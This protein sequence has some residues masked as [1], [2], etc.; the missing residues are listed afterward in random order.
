MGC[1]GGG[2]NTVVQP[3]RVGPKPDTKFE[4]P[5]KDRKCRDVIALIIFV[6]FLGVM[7]YV[8][9][10]AINKGNPQLLFY[11]TDSFGNVC[12]QD[13]D[14]IDG[15]AL[16]GR[17]T[18]G[19]KKLFYFDES[20]LTTVST[21]TTPTTTSGSVCVKTCPDAVADV[22]A[23][24]ALA[25]TG[26]KLCRY[27]VSTASYFDG[28][29]DGTDTCPNVPVAKTVS[30]YNR[31]VSETAADTLDKVGEALSDILDLID[32]NFGQK[33][34]EDLENSWRE[35]VY[36]TLVALG[37]SVVLLFLMR[38][39]APVLVWLVVGLVAVGTLAAIG[40]CWYSYYKE[41][42]D[43][44]LGIAIGVS[45]VGA[46]ILLILLILRKRIALVVQ[47]FKEAAKVI[48]WMP[49]I[50]LQP[51]ITLLILGGVT[52]GLTY[53]FLF[54]VT[55]RNAR[56]EATGDYVSWSQD[57]PMKGLVFLYLLGFLWITQF[58]IGCERL[59]VSGAVA[60]WFFTRDKKTL[61]NPLLTS[62][63]R[64]IRYHLGSVA[65]GSLIIALVSL[66]RMIL[67]FIEGRLSGSEN[68][69]AK[70]FLKCLTCCLWC[71]EKILKFLTAQAYIQIAI[72]GY[73]FCKAA[74]TA[75][76][77]VV[78]NAL[79]VAA[80]N[81]VGDF[82]LFLA[83]CGT[84]AI[85]A[86]VGI[87][88]FRD[89]ADIHYTWLPITMACIVAYFIAGCFFGLF[90]LIIDAVFMCFVEDCDRHDGVELPY[91]MSKGLMEFVKNANEAKKHAKRRKK[92]AQEQEQEDD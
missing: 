4:G 91:F 45:V 63:G 71:F 80:I 17:D 75:F 35:I 88:L 23:M 82:V 78:S 6:G 87:E 3:V 7:S 55:T 24:Q 30:I 26:T 28:A 69:V 14:P 85:V 52:A 11:P 1:C 90:E 54:I 61:H 58:I 57:E 36:L 5:I 86:V 12:N 79:R 25:S 56:V 89:R 31:C 47:L 83:K 44:W 60:L 18:S 27:D 9:Y 76:L 81:S 67:S 8:L 29:A 64:L 40:F 43:A 68:L 53:A 33:C 73:G 21:S 84:V 72:N 62:V 49:Q 92:E 38:F 66:V 70:V 50:L 16:S 39:V 42:T 65:F 13:N 20:L 19:L 22:T 32:D 15:A 46:I 34:G 77:V 10:Y 48:A 51:F 74:R 59:S 37:V 41:R 2:N